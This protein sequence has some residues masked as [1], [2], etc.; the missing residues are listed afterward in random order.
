MVKALGRAEIADL[1][2]RDCAIAAHAAVQLVQVPVIVSVVSVTL[3]RF[4]IQFDAVTL[5]SVEQIQRD[6][7]SFF[8]TAQWQGR[9]VVRA[10]L[11]SIPTTMVEAD[12][13]IA[14]IADR[15]RPVQ[16]R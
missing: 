8:C 13:S 10:S 3:Y 9:W 6:A 7:A 16:A 4:M 5:A 15:W 11:C 14:A 1:V 12:T 2:E